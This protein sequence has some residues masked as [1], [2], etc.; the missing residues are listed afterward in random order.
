MH[1]A[2]LYNRDRRLAG[3][4]L[5]MLRREAGL[6]FADNEPYFV[7]D[8]TTI[9]SRRMASGAGFPMWK[10]RFARIWCSRKRDSGNGRG[11]SAAALSAAEQAF[12]GQA[13]LAE[14]RIVGQD[15]HRRAPPSGDSSPAPLPRA[16]RPH[17]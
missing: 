8:E 3:L 6:T 15:A 12:S 14:A 10:S 4:V 11:G 16:T 13:R 9:P 1:G 2:V 7:S 5:D 17:A